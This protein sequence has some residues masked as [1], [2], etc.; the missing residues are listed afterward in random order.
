M[1]MVEIFFGI[2]TRRA[3]RHCTF[4]SVGDLI[5][6]IRTF[7]DAYNQRCEPFRWTKPPTRSSPKPT[8]K[9]TQTPTLGGTGFARLSGRRN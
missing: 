6:A 7:I 8:V 3:I 4:T 2:I 5:G 9:R 1:N